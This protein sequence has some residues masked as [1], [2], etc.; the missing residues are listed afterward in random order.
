MAQKVISMSKYR[1]LPSESVSNFNESDFDGYTDDLNDAE[2]RTVA[3]LRDTLPCPDIHDSSEIDTFSDPDFGAP[4]PS[5]SQYS[6][7]VA[8]SSELRS[9]LCLLKGGVCCLRN[10]LPTVQLTQVSDTQQRQGRSESNSIFIL[11][12]SDDDAGDDDVDDASNDAAGQSGEA[13]D[14]DDETSVQLIPEL[15]EN[16]PE[17]QKWEH[18]DRPGSLRLAHRYSVA[19]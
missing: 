13:E 12:P 9:E 6:D 19:A 5:L 1:I 7:L 11:S 18:L 17:K 3:A 2:W 14:T 16:L 15:Q 4:S 10:G 8:N